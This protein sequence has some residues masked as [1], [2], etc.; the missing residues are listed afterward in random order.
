[1][2]VS[3][4]AI[5]TILA[6]SPGNARDI[7][8]QDCWHHA[9]V[10]EA[11]RFTGKAGRMRLRPVG[12]VRGE[13]RRSVRRAELRATYKSGASPSIGPRKRRLVL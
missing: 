12:V 6:S 13:R 1:M 9:M 5:T 4:R 3:C 8:L 2:G 11:R 10:M 7:G